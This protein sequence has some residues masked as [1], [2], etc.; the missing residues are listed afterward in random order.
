MILI[1][2]EDLEKIN[3]LVLLKWLVTRKVIENGVGEQP[4]VQDL[5][6]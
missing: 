5:L 2:I 3:Y 1:K 4:W 6:D